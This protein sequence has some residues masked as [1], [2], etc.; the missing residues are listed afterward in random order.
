M[1]QTRKR[2]LG[3]T[4]LF[5]AVVLV[6]MTPWV[7]GAQSTSGACC[8]QTGPVAFDCAS[9]ELLGPGADLD[10][11]CN[12][13]N[14]GQSCSWNYSDQRCCEIAVA[15]GFGDVTCGRSGGCC[16]FTGPV[17]HDCASIENLGPG[18][19]LDGRCNEV[20]QGQSCSWDYSD[21]RCCEIAVDDGFGEASCGESGQCCVFTG[22]VGYD[23]ASIESLG[24][25]ADLDGRCNQVNQG[26]SCTWNFGDEKCCEIAFG[27]GFPGNVQCK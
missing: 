14:Q 23:C 11:R 26:Q 15:D 4:A 20:N 19:D 13:V 6:V 21:P 27:D 12:Q 7:A 8:A 22:P 5:I 17:G 18:A 16:L 3:R 10:G 25:G 1:E 24:P 2:A 9:I